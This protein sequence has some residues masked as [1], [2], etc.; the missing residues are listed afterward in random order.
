MSP[1]LSPLRLSRVPL[2][3]T[4]AASKKAHYEALNPGRGHHPGKARRQGPLQNLAEGGGPLQPKV[5][6][7]TGAPLPRILPPRALAF[8]PRRSGWLLLLPLR[9]PRGFEEVAALQRLRCGI[10]SQSRS[11]LRRRSGWAV[12]P[13]LT[14]QRHQHQG[15][16]APGRPS[17]VEG[18]PLLPL[19]SVFSEILFFIIYRTQKKAERTL[20]S[21]GGPLCYHR[22]ELH[23]GS[24]GPPV[25]RCLSGSEGTA[26]ER[27]AAGKQ[28]LIEFYFFILFDSASR[29]R[30]LSTQH[31]AVSPAHRRPPPG[32]PQHDA[33]KILLD[34]SIQKTSL[35]A[36]I[37]CASNHNTSTPWRLCD[38][39]CGRRDFHTAAAAAAAAAAA[40]NFTDRTSGSSSSSPQSCGKGECCALAQRPPLSP[41]TR[42][43]CSSSSRRQKEGSP[44]QVDASPSI[45]E[46]NGSPATEG[47]PPPPVWGALLRPY[48]SS[49]SYI[50]NQADRGLPLLSS[51]CKKLADLLFFHVFAVGYLTPPNSF[52]VNAHTDA[53]DLGPPTK[54]TLNAGDILYIPRGRGFAECRMAHKATTG[55]QTSLHI[56]ITIPTAE[57]S[58]ER[59]RL[60]G[61]LKGEEER[62]EA[63][64]AMI[65]EISKHLTY[66]SLLAASDAHAAEQVHPPAALA[67]AAVAAAAAAAAAAACIFA[68]FHAPPAFADS[69]K[70]SLRVNER[71][72]VLLCCWL[73]PLKIVARCL[74]ET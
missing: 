36:L 18:L 65:E 24:G 16:P 62:R 44:V 7:Q 19:S 73:L 72:C 23:Q 2:G 17:F 45:P 29:Q 50:L 37:D 8:I 64:K 46:V 61:G 67:A 25:T 1:L 71:Q 14:V 6:L 42:S 74:Y 69:T 53:Q 52:T 22:G 49:T 26:G 35:K 10:G 54:F 21:T 20:L 28:D 47:G 30:L 55:S 57:F 38:L 13:H 66:E 34:F 41:L 12:A 68:F 59:G 51:F 63:T 56:T 40:E 9:F 48:L 5:P 31:R 4:P 3:S 58:Y 70:S 60:A 33:P 39:H 27:A 15:A 32:G 43:S 11:Q